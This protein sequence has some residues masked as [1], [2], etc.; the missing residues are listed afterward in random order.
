VRISAAAALGQMGKDGAAF[1]AQVVLLLKD[2]DRDVRSAAAGALGQMGKDGAA[3]AAQVAPLLK[4]T[5][6]AVRSSAADALDDLGI[7]SNL[8]SDRYLQLVA[9]LDGLHGNAPADYPAFRAHLRLWSGGHEDLQLALDWLGNPSLEAIAERRLSSDETCHLLALFS[10]LWSHADPSTPCAH[11]MASRIAQVTAA[12]PSLPDEALVEILYRLRE[13]FKMQSRDYL[14]TQQAIGG[15]I[16]RVTAGK[17]LERA[18][19]TVGAHLGCWALLLIAYPRWVWVQTF[20]FWNPWFRKF[21]GFPYVGLVLRY[22]PMVRRQLFAPFL[23]VLVADAGLAQLSSEEWFPDCSVRDLDLDPRQQ[24]STPLAAAVPVLHGQLV[25]IGESGLGK[26]MCLRQLVQ[27]AVDAGRIVAFL[28]AED[29]QK[30]VIEALEERLQG[31][32]K[33]HAFLR[34]LIYAGAIDLGIDGLNQVPPDTRAKVSEFMSSFVRGNIMVTTQP[35]EWRPPRLARHYRLEPLPGDKIRAFLQTREPLLPHYA[36]LRGDVF[37]KACD[38]YVSAV[39]EVPN[40]DAPE[41]KAARE[42]LSNPLDATVA[43]ELLASG[44]IPDLHDLRAQQYDAMAA[45]YRDETGI[46]FPL[47]AIA[48]AAYEMRV[49]GVELFPAEKFPRELTYLANHRLLVRKQSLIAGDGAAQ[50]WWVFRHEKFLE[51]F[52][53]HAFRGANRARREQHLGD[54]PFR[55]VYLRLAQVLP[56]ADAE[57]LRE[58]FI[59]YASETGDHATSDEYIRLVARRRGIGAGKTSGLTLHLPE[60][61]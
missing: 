12:V 30:G 6:R 55:G 31:P 33:D 51:F 3:F 46:N 60:E 52:V 48:E 13:Q 9:A 44:T 1:A 2:T 54:P 15:A 8:E 42:V 27:L 39:L 38:A 35:M 34:D 19:I 18:T 21:L 49:A 47:P 23:D 53:V 10:K 41:V 59:R 5:D 56:L 16:D 20:C 29:C 50:E 7:Q 26:T 25:L 61:A 28:P 24:K 4:D 37:R 40:P 36:K 57:D 32:A 14:P 22:V 43:A 58:K 45:Q 11:E 17:W